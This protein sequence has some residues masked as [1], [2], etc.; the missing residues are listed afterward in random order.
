MAG[1]DQERL[2]WARADA[3]RLTLGLSQDDLRRL[4]INLV[5]A[6]LVD[7]R[8]ASLRERGIAA[9]GASCRGHEAAQI[10][11]VE[12]LHIG[13][14]YVLPYYRDLAAMLAIGMSPGAILLNALG[15]GDDPNTGGRMRPAQWNSR[16]L[17]VVSASG[18]VGTQTLHAAGIAFAAKIRHEQKVA[19]TFFGEGATSEGDFHEALNFAGLH[20][21][22]VIFVCENNGLALSTPQSAQM[23][24]R[25]VADRAAAYGMPGVVVDG[26]D[27]FA[28]IAAA[29]E[30]YARARA[31]KGPTLIEVL[32]PRMSAEDEEPDPR[33]PLVQFRNY[34]LSRGDLT[35]EL[36]R[37]F[38]RQIG[39]ELDE[40]ERAAVAALAPDPATVNDD[41]FASPIPDPDQP[42][43][44]RERPR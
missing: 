44:A 9:G 14:D 27:I 16:S 31:G 20:Q 40:A 38:H 3:R 17:N 34:L 21:L 24:V 5:L 23:P 35:P 39:E 1:N 18:L 26:G 4:Y 2:R 28:V 41:L 7:K 8:I 13:Q 12:P 22:G 43:P 29:R 33:D 10:G 19:V 25:Q 32:V 15:R 30:A 36:D 11:C 6:R 42:F 37:R